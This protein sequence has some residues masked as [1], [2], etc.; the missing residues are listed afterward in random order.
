MHEEQLKL[1]VEEEQEMWEYYYK[2]EQEAF[3]QYNY[4]KEE[5]NRIHE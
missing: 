4:L 1:T 5:E 3:D 2:M